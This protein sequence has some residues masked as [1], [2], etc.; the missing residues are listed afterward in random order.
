MLD[1]R[2]TFLDS[3][4]RRN[5]IKS[6][7]DLCNEAPGI[8][9]SVNILYPHSGFFLNKWSPCGRSQPFC[10]ARK[11]KG[12]PVRP[13]IVGYSLDPAFELPHR[14]NTSGCLYH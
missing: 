8:L 4:L 2:H 9:G 7:A 5:D 10:Q 6:Y 12:V 14:Q 11:A 3:R 13:F 1:S